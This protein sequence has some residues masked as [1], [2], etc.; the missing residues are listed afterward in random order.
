MGNDRSDPDIRWG[1]GDKWEIYGND[2]DRENDTI[3]E[4]PKRD[5]KVIN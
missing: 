5:M 3:V 2:P 4:P 1:G